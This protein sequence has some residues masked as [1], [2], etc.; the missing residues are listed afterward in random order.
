MNDKMN[1]FV[2]KFGGKIIEIDPSKSTV[3]N[4]FEISANP[5]ITIKDVLDENGELKSYDI[6]SKETSLTMDQ[7]K[8]AEE[9][10]SV[11][12]KSGVSIKA[13]LDELQ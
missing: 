6:L 3:F 8:V 10:L 13:F 5:Q 4:P 12:S 2:E 7:Y 1:D 9:L 11:F